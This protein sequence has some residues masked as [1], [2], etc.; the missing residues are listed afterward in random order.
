MVLILADLSVRFEAR[1]KMNE[2]ET[3]P[4]DLEEETKSDEVDYEKLYKELLEKQESETQEFS[5]EEVRGSVSVNAVDSDTRSSFSNT[6]NENW[7]SKENP[8][9]I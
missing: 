9:S 8:G 7:K 6:R 1:E 3:L 5:F 2:L 4:E